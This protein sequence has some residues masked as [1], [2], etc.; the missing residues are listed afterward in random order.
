MVNKEAP[1]EYESLTDYAARHGVNMGYLLGAIYATDVILPG[2]AKSKRP[3]YVVDRATRSQLDP[4]V[5]KIKART[6]QTSRSDRSGRQR[7]V[8]A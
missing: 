4:L 5:A 3:S 2:K 8:R 1:E 6:G 7:K